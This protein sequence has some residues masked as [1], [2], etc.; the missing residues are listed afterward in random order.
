MLLFV[1]V[2]DAS[3]N[4]G[5]PSFSNQA[6]V[7]H[8]GW[9]KYAEKR[10][11]IVAHAEKGRQLIFRCVYP[12]LQ[13]SCTVVPGKHIYKPYTY[14]PHILPGRQKQRFKPPLVDF[15]PVSRAHMTLPRACG[16]N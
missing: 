12:V 7:W 11:K 8:L 3:I 10:R 5:T 2:Y 6:R 1:V 4:L 9:G 14:T 15:A 13:C 16:C